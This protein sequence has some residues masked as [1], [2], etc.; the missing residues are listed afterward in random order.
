MLLPK[1]TVT[2]LF[3]IIFCVLFTP[4]VN[5]AKKNIHPARIQIGLIKQMKSLLQIVQVWR[6]KED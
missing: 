6:L 5:S 3:L 2:C 4:F 1:S